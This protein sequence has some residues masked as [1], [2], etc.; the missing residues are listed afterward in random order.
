VRGAD[1]PGPVFDIGI[2]EIAL[3]LVAALFVFG[4]DRLPQV[5]AQAARTLR[6]LRNLA[7]GARAEIT[8]AIGPELADLNL[9]A[10]LEELNPLSD[11]SEIRNLSPRRILNNAMFGAD[12]T[13]AEPVPA[14][15]ATA[16]LGAAAGV[17]AATVPTSGAPAPPVVPTAFD[18]D[19]T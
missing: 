5:V 15:E 8:E 10:Q 17:P 3:L 14:A 6:Q 2:G 11:V 7:A 9:R 4:P 13:I 12:D 18:S 1:Y 19:A 16:S